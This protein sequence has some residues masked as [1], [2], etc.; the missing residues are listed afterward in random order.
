MAL[1]LL[2]YLLILLAASVPKGMSP[3]RYADLV[4]G[5]VASLAI[6]ALTRVFLAR[7]PQAH[8]AVGIEPDARS[9]GRLL[10]GAAIGGAV[11][12]ATMALASVALGPIHFTA[13]IWPSVSVWAVTLAS[14]LTLACMEELGFRA[15]ALRML[16]RAIGPWR[17][18]CSIA[19]AFGA[20]HLLF[21]WS[22]S[23]IL[24][25]VIPSAL[26]FGVVALRSGGL[27]MPIGLHATLNIA[28]WMVG[29]KS[30]RG[31]WTL[32][33]DPV[34]AA[35]LTTYAPLIGMGV[36]LLAALVIARWP[37]RERP[38][39]LDAPGRVQAV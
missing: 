12:A 22:W 21:G 3:P 13:P 1:F 30:A 2:G 6:V 32:S 5:T 18:Q 17:A 19:L 35:R 29:E 34:H 39:P 31:I 15:Y 9:V 11:Y 10:G 26:L 25:G 4:W 36:T 8:R 28:Q 14:Y 20:S 37:T 38:A 23:A 33:V 16:V 27:A 7:E 24:L